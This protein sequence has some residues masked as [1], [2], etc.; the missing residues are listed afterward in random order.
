MRFVWPMLTPPD[1]NT[2]PYKNLNTHCCLNLWCYRTSP[3]GNY[4][5]HHCCNTY[6]WHRLFDRYM[7][8]CCCCNRLCST[9]LTQSNMMPH[10]LHYTL[11]VHYTLSDCT[12]RLLHNNLPLPW[13]VNS[14]LLPHSTLHPLSHNLMCCHTQLYATLCMYRTHTYP[15]CCCYRRLYRCNNHRLP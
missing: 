7:H 9:Q 5:Q 15:S 4:M 1:N 13:S 10:P 6:P 14:H 12:H 3:L 8:Y 2:P 11:Y